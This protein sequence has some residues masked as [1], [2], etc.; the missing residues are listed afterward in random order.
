MKSI[1]LKVHSQHILYRP[2]AAEEGDNVI[3]RDLTTN[4]C[5]HPSGTLTFPISFYKNEDLEGNVTFVNDNNNY[6]SCMGQ[7]VTFFRCCSTRFFA[8]IPIQWHQSWW[9][10]Q[11]ATLELRHA[12][13]ICTTWTTC[14]WTTWTTRTTWT[15]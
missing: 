10:Q 11:L 15:T 9:S 3:G 6:M 14:V 1:F 8:I 5:I 2:Q 13:I 7:I 4:A 12:C